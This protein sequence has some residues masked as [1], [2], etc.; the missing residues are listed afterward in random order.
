[1]PVVQ[2]RRIMPQYKHFNDFDIAQVDLKAF[3]DDVDEIPFGFGNVSI[4]LDDADQLEDDDD[5]LLLGKLGIDLLAQL[6]YFLNIT[7]SMRI[8]GDLIKKIQIGLNGRMAQMLLKEDS[9][10]IAFL[11]GNITFLGN[12]SKQTQNG[13]Q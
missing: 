8:F 5:F 2:H 13:P 3:A 11:S 12:N 9:D 7:R 4:G 6:A 1:M 10:L